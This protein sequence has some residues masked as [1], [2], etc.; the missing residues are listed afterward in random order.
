MVRDANSKV[1]SAERLKK[2]IEA[3][4]LLIGDRTLIKYCEMSGIGYSYACRLLKGHSGLPTRRT[5]AKM[6]SEEAAPQ[7]GVTY[8]K[9][10]E[11]CGYIEAEM[12][13]EV[14]RRP[15][16]NFSFP[17]SLILD[18]LIEKGQIGKIVDIGMTSGIFT[19]C[20]KPDNREVI[21]I[22]AFDNDR[23]IDDIKK[24]VM[25]R[26]VLAVELE[27]TNAAQ[28][29]ILTDRI[30]TYENFLDTY[31]QNLLDEMEVYLAYTEDYTVFKRQDR[32][33]PKSREGIINRNTLGIKLI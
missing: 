15:P 18:T 25:K 20:S 28:Y 26:L 3:I 9:L 17:L 32:I 2:L 13:D 10:M 29:I 23:E 21:V 8:Q 1:N 27:T 30:A 4:Q 11:I 6:T 5:L 16:K 19:L 12:K 24:D 22:P 33:I 14:E 31:G 7:N